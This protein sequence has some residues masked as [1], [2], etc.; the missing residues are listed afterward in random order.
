[1][2]VTVPTF[3]YNSDSSERV[4]GLTA[5]KMGLLERSVK[6]ELPPSPDA[7]DRWV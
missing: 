2:I 5:Y 6:G 1:M 3:H 7:D 4:D